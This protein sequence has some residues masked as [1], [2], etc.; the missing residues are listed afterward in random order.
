MKTVS[1]TIQE[2]VTTAQKEA[3]QATRKD[4]DSVVKNV[5]TELNTES[6]ETT[7]KNTVKVEAS[8][9][10][11]NMGDKF[12][13]TKQALQKACKFNWSIVKTFVGSLVGIAILPGL[14][15][16]GGSFYALTKIKEGKY[17]TLKI[18][19]C[20]FGATAV[21]CVASA[22]VAVAVGGAVNLAIAAAV[23]TTLYVGMSLGFKAWN[24]FKNRK[25][26]K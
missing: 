6:E 5:N 2:Q 3:V 20:L 21:A 8:N 11:K 25:T 24:W 7:M 4:V 19:L 17:L 15:I 18:A 13:K 12:P 26:A 22:V 10:F 14:L 23:S 16:G 9:F 1:E